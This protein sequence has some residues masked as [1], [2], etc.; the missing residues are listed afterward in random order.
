MTSG[1]VLKTIDCKSNVLSVQ[2]SP[3]GS[4][5]VIGLGSGANGGQVW[6]SCEVLKAYDFRDYVLFVQ[7]S[8]DGSQICVQWAQ[9]P[10]QK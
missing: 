2:F 8:N 10:A 9:N 7:F 1:K 4:K 3:D 5:I 6:V